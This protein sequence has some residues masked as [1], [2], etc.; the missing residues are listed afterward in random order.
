MA[1]IVA[2]DK[3]ASE[4]IYRLR[5]L[6]KKGTLEHVPLDINDVVGEVAQLVRNDVVLRNVPMAVD[7][8]PGLPSVRGDRVQLQQVVLNMVLNGLEAMAEPN[9]RDHALVIRTSWA[10]EAAVR[11]AVEDS[12]DG[13]DTEDVERLFQPLY[14]TKPEGLGMGLAIARTIVDAHG[15]Q[16]RASNN[17]GGGATFQFTLPVAAER[18]R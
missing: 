13:I 15:G 4:V 16:L 7:L 9:G 17:A 12:G 18:A 8:A 5:A 3:R 2:D 11:I 6:V 10:G 14:T 1:D